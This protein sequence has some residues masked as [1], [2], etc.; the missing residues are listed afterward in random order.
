MIMGLFLVVF[1]YYFNDYMD[2]DYQCSKVVNEI[3]VRIK[4]PIGLVDDS[5]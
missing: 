2:D 5:D 3:T 1:G 4:C